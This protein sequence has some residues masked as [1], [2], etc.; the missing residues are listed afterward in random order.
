M[1]PFDLID[2]AKRANSAAELISLAQS[3][4]I[5]LSEEDAQI[6][7][8]RWHDGAELS[9]EELEEVGGGFGQAFSPEIVCDFCLRGDK[10]SIN[11]SSGC[12]YF[13]DRC[14]RYCNGVKLK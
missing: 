1:T 11:M 6:Y 7:F 2:L 12:A 13:C 4:R 3:E 9:D 10:L 14:N 5:K 8:E